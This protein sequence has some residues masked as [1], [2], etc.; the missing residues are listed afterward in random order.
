MTVIGYVRVSTDQQAEN[1]E[2]LAIQVQA[3]ENWARE[4]NRR[5]GYWFTDAGV[6][7]HG[8]IAGREGLGM[9]IA[10]CGKGDTI[11]VARLDRLARDLITQ[12]AILGT[13][14]RAG[15]RIASCVDTEAAIL[16]PDSA[17]DPSRRL[18]R[19]VLGA[20]A[21]YERALIHL[22]TMAGRQRRLD[23]SGWCGGNLGIEM[24]KVPGGEP[25]LSEQGKEYV[26]F[27]LDCKSQGMSVAQT[28]RAFNE[29]FGTTHSPVTIYRMIRRAHSRHYR[30]QI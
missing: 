24:E 12:E 26:R 20:V 6:S 9:A 2:G 13:V 5:V 4:R 27:A 30:S 3:I 25:R 23:R 28:G 15:G 8:E 14:W 17:D 7:G 29:H 1:G 19:Q 10:Q 22:R 16:V 21:E 18:I 11:V